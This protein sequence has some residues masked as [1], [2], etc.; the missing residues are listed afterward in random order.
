MPLPDYVVNEKRVCL[1]IHGQVVDPAYTQLLM[2]NAELPL[3]DVLALDRVQKRL[4]IPDE[5]AQQLRRAKLIEGR[6]PNYHVSASVAE[7]TSTKAS[8][9]QMQSLDNRHYQELISEYIRK[10]GAA[11]RQNIDELV[12][13]K[14]GDGLSDKQKAD[15]IG[16]LL[17]ALRHAGKIENRGTRRHSVWHL[18]KDDE[19]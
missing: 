5:I 9:I 12:W 3:R 15:K 2:E 19:R 10:F 16:N 6:K 11:T 1:T 17:R 14:L 18:T 4:L 13:D 7:A 8:Y